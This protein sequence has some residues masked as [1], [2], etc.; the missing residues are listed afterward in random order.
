M[1]AYR[2]EYRRIMWYEGSCP[3]YRRECVYKKKR[4]KAY[5]VTERNFY[6][7]ISEKSEMVAGSGAGVYLWSTAERHC[8]E[9]ENRAK[10]SV[11]DALPSKKVDYK[12]L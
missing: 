9:N 7:A 3:Q 11:S 5:I 4:R 10:C 1:G 2:R 8:S 6:S 12:E